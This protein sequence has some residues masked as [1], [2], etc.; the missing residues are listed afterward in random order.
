MIT[1]DCLISAT[2]LGPNLNVAFGPNIV[3][4][5]RARLIAIRG[6]REPITVIDSTGTYTDMELTSL[7][8]SRTVKTGDA[9]AFKVS[10]KQLDVVTNERSVIEVAIPRAQ[11]PVVKGTKTSK[12]ADPPPPPDKR[13][14][15]HKLSNYLGHKF[16]SDK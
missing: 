9:L 14:S 10:F 13:S 4:G 12:T 8:F 11:A 7:V 16:T 5:C 2:P 15:L 1:R 6:T 3:E